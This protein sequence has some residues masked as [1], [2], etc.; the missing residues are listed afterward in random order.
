M[1]ITHFPHNILI[2]GFI[3]KLDSISFILG[4]ILFLLHLFLLLGKDKK[5]FNEVSNLQHYHEYKDTGKRLEKT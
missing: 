1:G 2:I 4:Q 5:K 3:Q